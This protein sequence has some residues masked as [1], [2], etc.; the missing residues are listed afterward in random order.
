MALLILPE[1]IF[2]LEKYDV[3]MTEISLLLGVMGVSIGIGCVAAGYLSGDAIRPRLVPYG[4]VALAIFF[5]L[6]GIVPASLPDLPRYWRILFSLVSLFILG[7][8]ISA[9][10]YI[11]PL[12]AL[13]QRLTPS[14]E[15][16]RYLGTANGLSFV[17]LL[18][19][20]ILFP[21]I[22]PFFVFPDGSR[23]PDRIFIVTAVLMFLGV[24][25]FVWRV[26]AR[27][28]SLAKVE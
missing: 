18:L 10:F 19:S 4:G 28:F 21:L 25:F 27:G 5:A 7:T 20:A 13:L 8:G 26:R 15:L 14:H 12:Q 22:Y 9:G 6:L 17:F 11:V 16:G 23:H 2:V 3:D 24:V 1:Y